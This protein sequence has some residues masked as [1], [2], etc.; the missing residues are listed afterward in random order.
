MNV[1]NGF[2]ER[3]KQAVRESRYTQKQLSEIIRIDQDTF[4]NYVKEKSFPDVQILM[5]LCQLLD[6]TPNWLLAGEEPIQEEF[7][8]TGDVGRL[9]DVEVDMLLKFRQL[10]IRDQEDVIGTINMKYNRTIKKGVS[11]RSRSGGEEAATKE[12]A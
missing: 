4:T 5:Q 6:K 2:G 12:F 10:D 7:I 9:S 1:L 11:S 8:D 3:L